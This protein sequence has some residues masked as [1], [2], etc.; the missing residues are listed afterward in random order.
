MTDSQLLIR[1][2]GLW[3]LAAVTLLLAGL[4]RLLRDGRWQRT[5]VAAWGE[6]WLA[7]LTSTLALLVADLV[8]PGPPTNTPAGGTSRAGLMVLAAVSEAGRVLHVALLL[9]GVLTFTRGFRHARWR[10]PAFAGALAWGTLVTLAAR[11]PD[12][13]LLWQATVA[14]VACG[15]GGGLL[16]ALPRARQGLGSRVTA[17]ALLATSGLW[18]ITLWAF[19]VE[20]AASPMLALTRAAHASAEVPFVMALGFGMVL[21]R[22]EDATREAD[23][24]RAELSVANDRLRRLAM[25][26]PLTDCLNRRAFTEGIGLEVAKS[27]FGTVAMLDLDGFK[28]INDAHGHAAGDE[29]LAHVA[30]LL[31]A[32][33]R[34]RDRL[35]RWGGDEFLL[36]MPGASP[37]GVAARLAA[38]VATAP[39]LPIGPSCIP[40]RPEVS[41][42]AEG[43]AGGDQLARAIEAADAAM[44]RA[45]RLRKGATGRETTPTPARRS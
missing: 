27:T 16:V 9:A 21:M 43:Y 32:S 33:T 36:V 18:V 6:A 14:I 41:I 20:P 15:A 5:Y 44:Y 37:D 2:I 17:A 8:V 10:L 29:V 7:L 12:G 4:F 38:A 25:Y 31:R 26:D 23:D 22:M 19:G 35:Y 42:G 30:G 45:K 40:V 11:G 1:I 28:A 39:A 34:P 24:A 13:A 3:T